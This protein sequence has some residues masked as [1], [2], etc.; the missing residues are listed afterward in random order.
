MWF[1]DVHQLGY[2][3]IFILLKTWL[4]HF[5]MLEFKGSLLLQKLSQVNLLDKL[6]KH[7]MYEYEAVWPDGHIIFFQI[8]PFT[9][10]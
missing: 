4:P 6:K 9:L 1:R 3:Y 2:F 7:V 5:F 8:W 10:M